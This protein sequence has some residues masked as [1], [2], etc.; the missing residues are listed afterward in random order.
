MFLGQ[1]SKYNGKFR[2][3][4][5]NKPPKNR[6]FQGKSMENIAFSWFSLS[7]LPYSKSQQPTCLPQG[8][9]PPLGVFLVERHNHASI[10]R[11][12][13]AQGI[14]SLLVFWSNFFW[15][16]V[17]NFRDPEKRSILPNAPEAPDLFLDPVSKDRMVSA[18][19]T[20][21]DTIR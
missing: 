12:L 4:L 9:S 14:M 5:M 15:K 19:V 21:A 18:S 17:A 13:D 2:S 7:E 3:D 20:D 8:S 10:R 11:V 16:S 1:E 6:I